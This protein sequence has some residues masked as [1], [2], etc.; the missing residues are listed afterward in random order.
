MPALERGQR[1]VGQALEVQVEEAEL[2]RLLDELHALSV[3]CC[4]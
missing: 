3:K 2:E 4:L 1:D